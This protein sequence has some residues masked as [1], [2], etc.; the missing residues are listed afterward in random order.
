VETPGVTDKITT[1]EA[2][3]GRFRLK[4][5]LR[6]AGG[7]ALLVAGLI[8]AIPGV[9]GPG[10]PMIVFALLILSDHFI[11]A[12]SVLDWMRAKARAAGLPEW[13]FLHHSRRSKDTRIRAIGDGRA[14][15]IKS[16]A[17]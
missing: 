14:P 17:D 4:S 2:S 15:Q 10:I 12:K 11:W 13:E 7:L 9:P 16:E 6:I 3:G 1:A 8:C 5:S